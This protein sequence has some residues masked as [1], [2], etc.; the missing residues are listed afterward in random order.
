M[1]P[2]VVLSAYIAT[3]FVLHGAIAWL[4]PIATDDW[5]LLVWSRVY[6][7][8]PIGDWAYE[9]IIRHP[10]LADLANHAIAHY[11]WLHAVL[12][13]IAALAVVF[14]MFAVAMRRLPRF[15]SWDD[16]RLIV[17]LSALLWI[18][19][20][21]VGLVF[22]HRPYAAAW[23]YGTAAA[24]W[25][26]AP[27]R[28]GWHP[29]KALMVIGALFVGTVTRPIGIFTTVAI[30]IIAVKERRGWHWLM[31]AAAVVGTAIGLVR[32]FFDFS[33]MGSSLTRT[34]AVVGEAAEVLALMLGLVIVKIIVGTLWPQ[35]RGDA[36]P[37]TSETLHWLAAWF[38]FAVVSLLGPRYSEAAVFPAAVLTC[39]AAIQ[40]VPWLMAS[41]PIRHVL[42]AIAIG[43]N[44]IAWTL[45][46]SKSLPQYAAF[47]ERIAAIK[48]AP[49]G[50]TVTVPPYH[51]IRP[52]FFVYG[53]DLQEAAR[54]QMIAA[55]LYGK[56]DIILSPAF[57][58]LEINPALDIRLEIE[59]VTPE[60]LRAAH[61]PEQFASSLKTAR[62]QFEV[63]VKELQW[64]L[65]KPFTAR[66]VIDRPYDLLHGRKLI[67][68]MYEGGT[69][70]TMKVTRKAQDDES[71]QA[72]VVIPRSFPR[73]HQETYLVV[74]SRV[75]PITYDS[76]A[77]Y[78]VQVLTTDV[79]AVIACD[80]ERCFLVDAFIP[81]L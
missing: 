28:C 80:A 78:R 35:H 54:R 3:L 7:N 63:A 79:H 17:V 21:R 19:G 71:R 5:D 65:A 32:G 10:T 72:L 24:L 1:K 50:A 55:A 23:L 44:L 66:L 39:I 34:Y 29:P 76:R 30:A 68:A 12:T 60:Q 49:R 75:S 56:R 46:V 38:G 57:R 52:S 18:A 73:T 26:F 77:R 33:G 61:V 6:R 2:R 37:E 27:F 62:A 67:G 51:Q 4:A 58:R 15:D 53:E 45:A 31:L 16:V 36:S 69:L 47:R 14:G 42:L 9:F 59:G 74:G 41:R 81:A 11:R 64:R 20:A 22:A 43:I 48:A 8:A 40:V 25:L 70:T 13:P